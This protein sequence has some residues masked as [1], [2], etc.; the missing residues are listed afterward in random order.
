MVRMLEEGLGTKQ[1]G[2]PARPVTG[3]WVDSSGRNILVRVGLLSSLAVSQ[4]LTRMAGERN[5]S[6]SASAIQFSPCNSWKV[7]TIGATGTKH[8]PLRPGHGKNPLASTNAF[9][10]ALEV[11]RLQISGNHHA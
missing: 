8:T 3:G 11:F 10:P 6:Y 2:L 5:L 9:E 7:I 4:T 1:K